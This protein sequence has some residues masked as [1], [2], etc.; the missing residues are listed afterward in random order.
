MDRKNQ[1]N[2]KVDHDRSQSSTDTKNLLELMEFD[3]DDILAEDA[4]QEAPQQAAPTPVKKKK[5]KKSLIYLTWV[6]EIILIVL[7][8][9]ITSAFIGQIKTVPNSSMESVLSEGDKVAVSRLTYRFKD[10]AR[11]D[12]VLY[13][14]DEDEELFGR[15]IGLPGD[16]IEITSNGVININGIRY[17]DSRTAY[18]LGQTTYPLT[19]EEGCYF[20]LCEN[21]REGKDS[22]YQ[23]IGTVEKDAIRGKILC[24]I[25]P[26]RS[27][28]VV[29]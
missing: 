8:L 27:L 18:I 26:V 6:K 29:K 15:I 20:I 4:P 28:G 25:W 3:F 10:P 5:K 12:L 17:Q 2:T 21:S 22:R 13:E 9:C 19:V 24:R 11:G 16:T 1:K 7:V 14:T 23:E